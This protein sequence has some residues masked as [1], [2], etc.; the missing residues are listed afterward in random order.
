MADKTTEIKIKV[1]R[2]DPALDES[3]RMEEYPV[4]YHEGMRVWNAL[5]NINE[6]QRANIS[7]RLSC[8]EYLCGSC[9]IMIN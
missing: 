2:F 7:W 9:T 3:P 4:E 5:D 1:F 6:T 8:R